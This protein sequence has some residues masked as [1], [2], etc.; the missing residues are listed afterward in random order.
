M[1]TIAAYARQLRV[2]LEDQAAIYERPDMT[3]QEWQYELETSLISRND[4]I[5]TILTLLEDAAYE[6]PRF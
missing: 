4:A 6:K 3:P 2:L 5:F 1:D